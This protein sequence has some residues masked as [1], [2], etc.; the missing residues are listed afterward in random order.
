MKVD[1]FT[2]REL[3]IQLNLEN[4]VSIN[5]ISQ[6]YLQVELINRKFFVWADS[7]RLAMTSYQLKNDLTF[8]A[9]FASAE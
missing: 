4:P 1:S 5:S 7:R 3:I 8:P 6:D 2:D 9:Q